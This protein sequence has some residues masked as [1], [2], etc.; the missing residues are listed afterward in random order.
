MPTMAD[1]ENLLTEEELVPISTERANPDLPTPADMIKAEQLHNQQVQSTTETTPEEQERKAPQEEQERKA[2]TE[3]KILVLKAKIEAGE[4]LT[5][6]E[7]QLAA[8]IDKQI[9]IPKD[10]PKLAYRIN[11]NEITYDEAKAKMLEYHKLDPAIAL[12]PESE[13][14]MVESWVKIANQQ[15]ANRSIDRGY[16]DNAAERQ[17]IA[18]EKARLEQAAMNLLQQQRRLIET[19][20]KQDAILSKR[21][22]EDELYHEDGRI[23]PVKLEEYTAQRQAIREAPEIDAEIKNIEQDIRQTQR[24]L[25]IV[26]LNEF[27]YAHPEYKTKEPIE[28]IAQKITNNDPTVDP[29]D[30]IKVREMNEFLVMSDPQRGITIEDNYQFNL[31]RG[32]L[33]VKPPVHTSETPNKTNTPTLPKPK[34][35]LQK[36]ELFRQNMLRKT[37]GGKGT[38]SPTHQPTPTQARGMIEHAHKVLGQNTTDPFLK[39]FNY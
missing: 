6:E 24:N 29:E 28:I 33:A 5:D 27:V 17:R 20:K 4:E 8:E 14:I 32:S 34:T 39:E 7:N 36:V 1:N 22:S 2:T 11:G 26:T 23:D 13:K 15:E 19:R 31:R 21:I 25:D 3:E 18:M 9:E 16:K 38:G 35:M 12:N 10:E 30:K 37:P